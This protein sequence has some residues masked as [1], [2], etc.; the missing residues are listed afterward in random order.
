MPEDVIVEEEISEQTEDVDGEAG[1]DNFVSDEEKEMEESA[2]NEKGTDDEPE[3]KVD[4]DDKVEKDKSVDQE[5]KSEE[6]QKKEPDEKLL[7]QDVIDN[8]IKDREIKEG[9]PTDGTPP[10]SDS[11]QEERKPPEDAPP[12][13]LTKE[14]ISEYLKSIDNNELPGE[15]IIGDNVINLKEFANDYP[16]EFNTTKILSSVI[17]QQTINDLIEKG[18]IITKDAAGSFQNDTIKVVGELQQEIADLKFWGEVYDVHSDA[19]KINND[20]AFKDAWLGKQSKAI[21]ALAKSIQTPQDAIAI[22]DLYKSDIAK[23][24][25][26]E[27]DEKAT[28]K[29]KTEVD[30]H[31]GT[32]R[33]KTT[34]S[35]SDGIQPDDDEKAFDS[36]AE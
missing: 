2:P 1:F 19:K 30:L 15:V 9:V 26:A 21:Q 6:V 4:A 35:Q 27:F 13:K 12:A 33:G 16:D 3:T 10:P 18:V 5:T 11:E 25:V 29:K 7:P 31:K 8:I 32:M 24:N 22:L 28:N 34:A 23:S 36:Y 14:S 17:A 20:P